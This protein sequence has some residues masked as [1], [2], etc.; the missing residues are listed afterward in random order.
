MSNDRV[1]LGA[2]CAEAGV[3]LHQMIS[4]MHRDGAILLIPGTDD[5]RCHLWLPGFED[6]APD[7]EC[8]FIPVHPDIE[9]V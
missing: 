9:P 2:A 1:D 7:C 8:R 3:P 5:P 4:W 6:H